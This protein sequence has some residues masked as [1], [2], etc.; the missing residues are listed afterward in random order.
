M[1]DP[2]GEEWLL[3]GT[4]ARRLR[5][6]EQTV[7][8]WCYRPGVR[9]YRIGAHRWVNLSDAR[10]AEAA[11]RYRLRESGRIVR[12][13]DVSALNETG[14]EDGCPPPCA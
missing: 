7:W 12:A 10:R 8:V 5:V 14:G 13:G 2:N 11:W 6:R 3:A 1:I 4:V 9:S